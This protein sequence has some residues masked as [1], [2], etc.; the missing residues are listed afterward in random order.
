MNLSNSQRVIKL[1][2]N[3]ITNPW[4]IPPYLKH[5]VFTKK[6]PIEWDLPW[7]P[8]KA[9][10]AMDQIAVGKSF[11]EW[12]T[13]GSTTR[14]GKVTL[15]HVAVEDD[16]KW[17]QM[18]KGYCSK[19]LLDKI[20]FVEAPFDFRK[21]QHFAESAYL[22]SL[23]RSYDIVVVDGQDRTFRERITCFKHAEMFAREGSLIVVDDFWRYKELLRA[24]RASHVE[25]HESVGPCRMGVTSTAFFHY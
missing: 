3:L 10:R 12:G 23:D 17:L 19:E 5:N 20:K 9:I 2:G 25:I 7:W 4:L 22:H 1:F 6:Y 21:P 13:G 15:E 11:F 18:L 14:Y 8:Y 24:N 16:V